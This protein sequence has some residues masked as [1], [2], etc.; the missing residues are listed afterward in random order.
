MDQAVLPPL[1]H[2]L[3]ARPWP[4]LYGTTLGDRDEC[5]ICMEELGRAAEGE[6]GGGAVLLVVQLGCRHSYCEPCMRRLM[7]RGMA[8]TCPQCWAVVSP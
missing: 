2:G 8:A 5:S 7:Q 6:A 3:V 1:P 4:V